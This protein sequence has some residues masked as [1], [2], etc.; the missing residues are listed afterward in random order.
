MR[1]GRV[2]ARI[3]ALGAAL[4][5]AT[6]WPM[7]P[8]RADPAGERT[9]VGGIE[10]TVV[11]SLV[12]VSGRAAFVDVP[13]RVG[14]DPEGDALVGGL[15]GDLTSA[16]VARPKAEQERLAFTL[17]IADQPDEGGIPEA[18][19]YNWYLEV[20]DR[21][22]AGDCEPGAADPQC[23]DYWLQAMRSDQATNPGN[24]EPVYLL[25][26]CEGI[27]I[28]SMCPVVDRFTG[29]MENG[30]VQ[31]DVPMAAIRAEEG[32]T[33]LTTGVTVTFGAT[34]LVLLPG[35]DSAD[36]LSPD[37]YTV[38]SPEVRLGLAPA[39]SPDEEI[40]LPVAASVSPDGS[41]AG[42]LDTTGLPPGS[43]RVVVEACFGPASCGRGEANITLG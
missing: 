8:S 18:I 42:A 27:L 32:G 37:A 7:S 3:W 41:F 23:A 19:E 1:I 4:V 24:L 12:E 43:Y 2:S 9:T 16:T 34:S 15:G 40:E 25:R 17:G 11:G 30:I 20:R 36:E 14:E 26:Q 6:G 13:I 5:L 38:P 22:Y 21:G 31:V 10:T 39:G 29:V 28:I 35:P 33:V